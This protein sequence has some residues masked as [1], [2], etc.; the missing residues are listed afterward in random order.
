MQYSSAIMTNPSLR[1]KTQH[2]TEDFDAEA[3]NGTLPA[4]SFLKPGD[5]DGHP[6]YSTLSA[7]EAF[8]TH[9]VDEVQNNPTLWASTAIFVTCDEG[10]GYYDSGYIQPVSFFGD[11]TRVPMVVIS[12]YAK[13]GAISHSYTDHVSIL[14]FIERNWKLSPLSSQS[15]DN[16]PDPTSTAGNP[17]VPTNPPAIGDLFDLFNFSSKQAT[18]APP[19][20]LRG[21]WRQ[22]A[23][24]EPVSN[25][26]R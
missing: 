16:L 21:G 23:G 7:F 10:G 19:P 25:F 22:G 3:T 5:D 2:G 14:K 13:P 12:P 26:Q 9:A 24:A 4:V 11:G 15:E 18:T 8:V 17:Y 20:P 6:G 1:A